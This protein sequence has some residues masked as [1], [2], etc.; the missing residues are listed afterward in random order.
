VANVDA[1]IAAVG[2]S[3]SA[4]LN[5]AFASCPLKEAMPHQKT[6][7]VEKERPFYYVVQK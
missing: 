4:I 7:S 3:E 5:Y 1:I 2:A 6:E